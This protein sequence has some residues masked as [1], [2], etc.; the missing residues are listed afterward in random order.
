MAYINEISPIK[1][2]NIFH[3]F[4]PIIN[5]S[6]DEI[7]GFEALIRS[8]EI[9]NPEVLFQKAKNEG[10]LYELDMLSIRLACET[11]KKECLQEE[12]SAFTLFINI[13]PSTLCHQHFYEEFIKIIEEVALDFQNIVIEINEKEKTNIYRLHK[14]IQQLKQVGFR[15]ALDD[16]GKGNS[17]FNSIEIETHIAKIDR[18]YAMNLKTDSKKKLFIQSIM[19]SFSANIF[20]V[21]EGIETEEDCHVAKQLGIHYGQGYYF[22]RPGSLKNFI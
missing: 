3:V 19:E 20:I 21:L 10:L 22:G 15:I 16:L 14:N 11:F 2:L 9:P 7:I 17:I 12:P 5:L 13:F 1:K 4:Q 8:E 6:N 18:F